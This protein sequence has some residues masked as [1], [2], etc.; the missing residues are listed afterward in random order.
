MKTV[1]YSLALFPALLAGPVLANQATLNHYQQLARQENPAFTGFSAERGQAFY[2]SQSSASGK[3]MSCASCHTADP[4]QPGK[5]PAFRTLAP[6]APAQTPARFTDLTKVE[7]WFRRNCDDVYKRA[8]TTQEK[9]DL[10]AWIL[11]V[12]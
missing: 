8:C 10:V 7:K 5:T 12:K 9:G 1:L 11:T 4:R 3:A 2:S 6:F